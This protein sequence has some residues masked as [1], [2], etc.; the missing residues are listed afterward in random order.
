MPQ[1]HEQLRGMFDATF[2]E[3]FVNIVDD[4]GSNGL[5]AVRLMQQVARQR[6]GGYFRNVLMLADRGD[7]LLVETA[8]ADTIR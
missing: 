1:R 6:G 7:L 4:H 3:R 8:K 5:A 2:V